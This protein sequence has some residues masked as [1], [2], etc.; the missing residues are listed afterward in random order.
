[1]FVL[2]LFVRCKTQYKKTRQRLQEISF[3]LF[4]LSKESESISLSG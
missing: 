2:N 1:M 3:R 4:L